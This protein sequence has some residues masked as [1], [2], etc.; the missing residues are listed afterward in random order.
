[1]PVLGLGT[2]LIPDGQPAYAAVSA[3]LD[4][5][6]RSIDTARVYG[7]EASVGRA[8]RDSGLARNSLF[9]TSKLPAEIK[10]PNAARASFEETMAQTGLDYL[11]LY[12]IH[13]PWP[14]DDIGRDCTEGNRQVWRVLEEIWAEG[15]VRAIGVSNFNGADLDALSETARIIPMVNQIPFGIGSDQDATIAYC[16]AKEIVLQAYSPLAHGRLL[17]RAELP[18]VAARYGRSVAQLCN[19]YVVQKGLAPLP[20]TTH[21]ERMKE[22]ADIDFVIGPDDMAYLDSLARAQ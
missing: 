2:W 1:M 19:R 5:G 3:A 15:R 9:I 11:D 7:N 12:L 13:A 18:T 6:Y 10:E 22:N 20:K 4:L 21:P 14:W 8:V 16:A 17:A